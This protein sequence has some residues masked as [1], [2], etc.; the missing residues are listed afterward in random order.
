MRA[1]RAGYAADAEAVR[2]GE[3]DRGYGWVIFA[4]VR[5]GLT[6][7]L[8]IVDEHR[9]DQAFSLLRGQGPLRDRRSQGVGMDRLVPRVLQVVEAD[10]AHA[11]ALNRFS[12]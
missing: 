1:A 7:T 3:D 2:P 6:G 10:L 4:G 5:L 12:S 8:D 9:G 11:G